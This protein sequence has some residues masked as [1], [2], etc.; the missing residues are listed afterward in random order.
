MASSI[1]N[2][3]VALGNAAGGGKSNAIMRQIAQYAPQ[4]MAWACRTIEGPRPATGSR[5]NSPAGYADVLANGWGGAA[6]GIAACMA[7]LLPALDEAMRAATGNND[8]GYLSTGSMEA[9]SRVA[10]KL[11]NALNACASQPPPLGPA[12]APIKAALGNTI[13]QL[14]LFACEEV[15]QCSDAAV[16]EA[17]KKACLFNDIV[18]SQ[19][20]PGFTPETGYSR[21]GFCCCSQAGPNNNFAG[22]WSVMEEHRCID[23][24]WSFRPGTCGP[25]LSNPPTPAEIAARRVAFVPSTPAECAQFQA[26]GFPGPQ[27]VACNG[28]RFFAVGPN[29]PPS[30][31]DVQ[32]CPWGHFLEG[33]SVVGNY[34]FNATC[35]ANPPWQVG[36]GGTG[37]GTGGTARA[38]GG[39]ASWTSGGS[40]SWTSGG[41]AP[42]TSGGTTLGSGGT[43]SWTSGGTPPASGGVSGVSAFQN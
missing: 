40:A 20:V 18:A 2:Q 29:P 34:I 32:C 33:G 8:Y 3:M 14:G 5:C 13:A 21:D 22:P 4:I 42:W 39:S 35:V 24:G 16:C 27:A 26:G 31:E 28:Q 37:D 10:C 30:V 6:G 23:R 36:E 19:P 9:I 25:R 43:A 11:G 38:S 17:T 1:I 41:S 15:M 12:L 7:S